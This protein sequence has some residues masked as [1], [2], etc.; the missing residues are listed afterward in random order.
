MATTTVTGTAEI[1]DTYCLP[2]TSFTHHNLGSYPGVYGG[3]ETGGWAYAALWRVATT[4]IPGGDITGWR[5]KGY[6]ISD[7]TYSVNGHTLEI[8]AV[9]DAND[10]IEGTGN[11]EVQAGSVDWEDTQHGTSSWAGSAGCKTPTTD[12]RTTPTMTYDY[13][14]Y[15]AGPDVLETI[16]M[17]SVITWLTNW[18]DSVWT[19]QGFVWHA[20]SSWPANSLIG[21]RSTEYGSNDPYFEIDYDPVTYGMILS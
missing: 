8:Y 9:A 18:R 21:F 1:E 3:G 11:F 12:Y 6:R 20:A 5:H 15:S 17:D 7:G 19:N 16:T 14:S 4:S 13:N 2:N 10:W